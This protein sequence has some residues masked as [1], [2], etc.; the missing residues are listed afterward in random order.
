LIPIFAKIAK[1]GPKEAISR[2]KKRL[3]TSAELPV[4]FA[5]T[6]QKVDKVRQSV[7]CLNGA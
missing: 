2:R 7:P 5:D 4:A 6:F 1:F 3:S